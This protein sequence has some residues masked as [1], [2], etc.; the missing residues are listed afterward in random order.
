MIT[1]DTCIVALLKHVL[2]LATTLNSHSI[3]S[4][5]IACMNDLSNDIFLAI[6]LLDLLNLY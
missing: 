5:K 6:S 3:L 4:I 1:D 2:I